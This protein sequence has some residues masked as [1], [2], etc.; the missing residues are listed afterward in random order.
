MIK[1][2]H[3]LWC[4]D[5]FYKKAILN[6]KDWDEN[7]G[8]S[9]I[10]TVMMDE[11][12]ELLHHKN[13]EHLLDKWTNALQ[14][15]MGIPPKYFPEIKDIVRELWTVNFDNLSYNESLN[16]TGKLILFLREY[17]YTDPLWIE[18]NTSKSRGFGDF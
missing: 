15:R 17:T 1:I 4:C 11:I 9:R 2:N 16:E 10:W 13:D 5:F 12:P 6:P 3:L 18:K 7:I 14:L 8:D